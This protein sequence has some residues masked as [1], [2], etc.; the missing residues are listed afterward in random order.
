VVREAKAAKRP[1]AA[2]SFEVV[3]AHTAKAELERESKGKDTHIQKK[4]SAID[5]RRDGKISTSPWSLRRKPVP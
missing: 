4:I 5:K 1:Y 2:P 3:D